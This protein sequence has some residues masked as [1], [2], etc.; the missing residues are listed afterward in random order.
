LK[1]EADS[2]KPDVICLLAFK[3]ALEIVKVRLVKNLK[4]EADS[5]KQDLGFSSEK[6]FRLV[7]NLNPAA[8]SAKQKELV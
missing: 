2:A 5:T 8:D 1:P 3:K 6:L 4:P 7:L